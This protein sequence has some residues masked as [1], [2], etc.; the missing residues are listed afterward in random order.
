MLVTP[1]TS[2]Q[3][4]RDIHVCYLS[5]TLSL[6]QPTWS[7]YPYHLVFV[8]WYPYSLVLLIW[9]PYALISFHGN[10]AH[11]FGCGVAMGCYGLFVVPKTAIVTSQWYYRYCFTGYVLNVSETPDN[12]LT[13][14]M[15]GDYRLSIDK[16]FVGFNAIYYAFLRNIPIYIEG[17]NCMLSTVPGLFSRGS[18]V[19][20]RTPLSSWWLGWRRHARAGK[21]FYHKSLEL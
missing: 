17:R 9:Y 19:G 5:S 12:A 1:M 15:H 6:I 14:R 11:C 2:L 13:T 20:P 8:I 3:N 7:A 18:A 4:C 16:F 10:T 21:T